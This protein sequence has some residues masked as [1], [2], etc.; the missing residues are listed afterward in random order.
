MRSPLRSVSLALCLCL[1]GSWIL[2]GCSGE[3]AA[4]QPRSLEAG[5]NG[6]TVSPADGTITFTR[7]GETLLAFPADALE[8]GV[9]D[10]LDDARNYDPYRVYVPFALYEDPPGLTWLTPSSMEVADESPTSLSLSLAYAE[11]RATLTLTADGDEIA[12]KLV[13]SEPAEGER[14]VAFFRLRPRVT[15]DEGFY[16]LGEHFDA[17]EHRGRVRAM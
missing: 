11:A 1:S 13:P 6:V 2:A 14:P 4:P 5:D 3:G 17:P 12:A 16:G 7:E 15:D 8:L 9:V 10:A